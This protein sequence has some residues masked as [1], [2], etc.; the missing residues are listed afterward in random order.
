MHL[1]KQRGELV[2]HLVHVCLESRLFVLC[3]LLQFLNQSIIF[4]GQI[5]FYLGFG[6]LQLLYCLFQLLHIAC[7]V[8][9]FPL[10]LLSMHGKCI[11]LLLDQTRQILY[12]HLCG[13]KSF[14]LVSLVRD[15][16]IPN[17]L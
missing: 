8:Q 15:T 11:L 16:R 1:I 12:L 9:S 6:S 13:G 7:Q 3:E 17:Q 14:L 4:E 10:V 2:L 5:L